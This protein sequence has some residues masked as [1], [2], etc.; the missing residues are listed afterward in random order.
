MRTSTDRRHPKRSFV[1]ALLPAL[2]LAAMLP[3]GVSAQADESAASAIVD[4][5]V[6][7]L[8]DEGVREAQTVLVED[9]RIAAIGPAGEVAVPDGAEVIDGQGAYLIPGLVDGHFHVDGDPTNL[10][11]A[12]A[13]GQTTMTALNASPDDLALAAEVAAGE[14]FGPRI[15][16]GPS[17]SGLLPVSEYAIRRVSQAAS[18][19]FDTDAATEAFGLTLEPAAAEQFVRRAYEAGADFIKIN[20]FVNR[21]VFDAAVAMA[22]ELGL[23]VSGHVSGQ[24]GLEHFVESGAHVHHALE[25]APFLSSTDIPG[26]PIQRWG[27]DLVDEKLP[28]F[29]E[30]MK[31]H[32]QWLTPTV[33]IGAQ[34]AR[35]FD[36]P[37][38]VAARPEL[39]Y[40]DPATRRVRD[41]PDANQLYDSIG[42]GEDNPGLGDEILAFDERLVHDLH[43]AGIPLIAGTDAGAVPWSVKGFEL[44]E[45]LE[46]FVEA[47]LTPQEALESASRVTAEFYGQDDEWGT[48]EVGKEA[49]LVLLGSDPLEDISNVR[50]IAG[51][52]LGGV[53]LPQ[54]ELQSML[55]EIVAGYEAQATIELEP[56]ANADLGIS[57]VAPA[58][59]TELDAGVLTR[60]DPDSD[61]TFL[62][63][64]AAPAEGADELVAGVLQNFGASEAGQP[65]DSF[66]VGDLTWELF[67]PQGELGIVMATSISG[68]SAYVIAI[69]ALPDEIEALTES[70]LQPAVIAFTPEP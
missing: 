15:I 30:L 70:V 18:P 68:E 37:E 48:I 62:V 20:V 26:I 13:N 58:G 17:L 38:A 61:P 42:T 67:M 55:D 6:I 45:E 24:I 21:E 43:A 64:L 32:D 44:A 52:M 10:V 47:G 51:V 22:D 7:S 39:R 19:L 4:V 1:T 69:A 53:W 25:V 28:G 5:N 56:Y 16:T 40:V 66:E 33:G 50:D 65:V 63:Q 41:D 60:S 23:P 54:S 46:L 35:I 14:R 36:D 27:F 31:E 2:L 12:L 34:L 59:W 8:S 49:D 3:A 57:G 29:I 9:G 11:L